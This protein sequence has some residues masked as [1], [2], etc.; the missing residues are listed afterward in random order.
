MN[1]Y[2][3]MKEDPYAGMRQSG[4][5]DELAHALRRGGKIGAKGTKRVA[6]NGLK[7]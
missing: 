1:L 4:E 7:K 3:L 2:K 5:K 6:V